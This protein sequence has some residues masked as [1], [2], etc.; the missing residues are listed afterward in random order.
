M[1]IAYLLVNSVNKYPDRIAIISEKKRFSYR[2]FN[3]RVNRLAHALRRYGCKKGDRVALMFFNTYQFAEIYFA[4]IKLGAILTPVNFRFV[5]EEIEYIVNNSESSFFFFAKEFQETIASIYQGLHTVKNF[6]GVDAP[7]GNFAHDY[8]SF[9][10]LGE[11]YEPEVE[12]WEND[13]CQIMYTSGTTGKPKGAIITHGNVLWNLMN[14]IV[15]REDHPGEISL[16]IGPLYHTAALN[17]HFTIQIA[18]CGT[19]ILIKKFDPETVLQYIEKEKVNVIS[20]SPAMYNLLLQYPKLHH[21]DTHSITKCTAGS[22]IL[23]QEIKERLVEIFP[24]ANGIYDVYGCTEASPTITI[25]SGRDSFRKHGSVGPPVPFLQARIVNEDGRTLPPNQ[26]GELVCQGPNVMQ[27]YYKNE[28]ATKETIKGGW[29][30]TGD[31][32]TIDD[33]GYLYIVDRKK[34]MIVSGG[35]NIYPREIE[36]VLFRHSAIADVAV[37][38][39]PDPIWGETVKAFIVLKEGKMINEQEVIDFCKDHLASYKKPR[40]IEFVSSIPKNPSGKP[41]K[42]LLKERDGKG[43]DGEKVSNLKLLTKNK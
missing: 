29:L 33:D 7:K 21:F 22:A 17:N 30:Y 34:D 12:I 16:I 15:G 25:L 10:S 23:P 26:I 13:P 42:R 39:I 35:E 19:S 36:E 6:I 2:I 4:T 24:N 1:N 41:L 37:V 27:E 38:G 18:L 40:A 28:E 3:Q 9:L 11:L 8:E 43:G 32:A 31:L 20:G 14:T 5:G